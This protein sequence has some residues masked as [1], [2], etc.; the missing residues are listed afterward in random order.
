MKYLLLCSCVTH[1]FAPPLRAVPLETPAVLA[2]RETAIAGGGGLGFGSRDL[3]FYEAHV[4]V[5]R[6]LSER[7]EGS[8]ETN[9]FFSNQPAEN[10]ATFRAGAKV[11]VGG[12]PARCIFALTAGLG[13]GPYDHGALFAAEAGAIVGWENRWLV[14]FLSARAG[15]SAPAGARP[16]YDGNSCDLDKPPPC[17]AIYN[18]PSVDGILSLGGGLRLPLDFGF[19]PRFSLIAA[20]GFSWVF[21]PD[22]LQNV[23]AISGAA[24]AAF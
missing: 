16:V 18:T 2:P 17:G 7:V 19:K 11:C 1:A 15:V 14:P 20:Y 9:A 3:G 22:T 12:A 10:A 24:E 4:R 5:R 23:H 8:L 13:G 21:D 6:G